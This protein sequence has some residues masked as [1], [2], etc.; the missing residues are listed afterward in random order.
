MKLLYTGADLREGRGGGGELKMP[1]MPNISQSTFSNVSGVTH[2]LT[3][4]TLLLL[5]ASQTLLFVIKI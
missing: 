5:C 3:V 4:K 1:E 2:P